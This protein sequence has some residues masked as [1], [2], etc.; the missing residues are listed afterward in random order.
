MLPT[1]IIFSPKKFPLKPS[2]MAIILEDYFLEGA[3]AKTTRLFLV[4][5]LYAQLCVCVTCGTQIST[6]LL[7][8]PPPSK[9]YPLNPPAEH[10]G[11]FPFKMIRRWFFA[12]THPPE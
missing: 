6:S 12:P 8:T 5:A 7:T 4:Q 10:L 3:A 11:K 9:N 1:K 2:S